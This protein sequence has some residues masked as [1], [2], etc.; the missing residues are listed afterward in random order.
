MQFD[1]AILLTVVTTVATASIA[2]WAN[3]PSRNR[4]LKDI[5]IY[6]ALKND[7]I[8]ESDFANLVRLRSSISDQLENIVIPIKRYTSL[9]IVIST[10]MLVTILVLAFTVFW[11]MTGNAVVD[12]IIRLIAAAPIG[13]FCGWLPSKI[14]YTA[15]KRREDRTMKRVMELSTKHKNRDTESNEDNCEHDKQRNE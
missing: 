12:T 13:C 7:A 11:N 2:A 3:A 8:F 6:N 1:Y 14:L 10:A 15:L 4:L 5:E 9:S